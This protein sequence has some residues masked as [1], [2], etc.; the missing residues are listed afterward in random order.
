MTERRKMQRDFLRRVG[1]NAETFK[2]LFD[3]LPDATFYMMDDQDRIMAYNRRN[4][5]NSNIRNEMEIVGKKSSEVFPSVLA[6]VYMA[7]DR[8]VRRTGKPILNRVYGHGADRSTDLRIVNI[9]PLR[10][11]RDKI[12]GTVCLYRTVASDESKPDWYG[13]IRQAVAYIDAHFAEPLA[14]P[15][16]ARVS[17]MSESSFRRTFKQVME[18]TPG[19]YIATIRINHARK[20]LATT[21]MKIHDIAE[22]C[23]FYDQ[24]HFIRT[25]KRLRRQTPAQYRHAH[26]SV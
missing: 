24:S 23:G 10:D 7:R 20:L 6:E 9:Y 25:F 8:E 21:G 26:F 1:P 2:A 4:C 15:D 16:L 19:S 14:L 5:E 18:I 13:A 12:I 3:A 22:A 11:V 17:G